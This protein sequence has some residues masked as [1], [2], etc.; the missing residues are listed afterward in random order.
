MLKK[1]SVGT[2]LR[3]HWFEVYSNAEGKAFGSLTFHTNNIKI[4]VFAK[5]EVLTENGNAHSVVQGTN[6]ETADDLPF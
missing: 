2:T 4:L 1:R 3:A 5:K 6:S